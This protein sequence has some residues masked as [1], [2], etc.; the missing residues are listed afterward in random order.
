MTQSIRYF[1]CLPFFFN[2]REKSLF[3]IFV[4]AFATS[5]AIQLGLKEE[6]VVYH[7][8]TRKSVI[9]VKNNFHFR[10]K[11]IPHF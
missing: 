7:N 10:K 11:K 2:E 8:V 4:P 5:Q 6:N 1:T 9:L 3:H